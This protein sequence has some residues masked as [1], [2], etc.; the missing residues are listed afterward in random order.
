MSSDMQKRDLAAPSRDHP[1][2][3]AL[4]Q[5]AHY[6]KGGIGHWFRDFRDRKVFSLL[7]GKGGWVVDLGCGEG[8]TLEKLKKVFPGK[9]SVGIDVSRENAKVCRLHGLPAL[10]GDVHRLSLKAGTMDSCLLMDVI[11]HI[12]DP[13]GVL[14]EILRVLMPGGSLILV[15]PNDGIFFLARIL[16]LKFREAFHD[17]GHLRGWNP[18]RM[19]GLLEKKGFRVRRRMNLP[20]LFWPI[21]LYHLVQVEK[22]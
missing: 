13:E 15:F 4:S 3:R 21:S 20:F 14:E 22:P 7:E 1:W 5:R 18:G 11:E 17:P 16:F 12:E 10:C 8:I 2:G 6:A 9:R 19:K